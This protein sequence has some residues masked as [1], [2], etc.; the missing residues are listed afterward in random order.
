MK[1]IA[2]VA[3]LL[4]TIVGVDSAT[5]QEIDRSAVD[6]VFADYDQT[7]SPGCALGVV[8]G[9]ALVYGRGYGM[10][11][12]DYGIAITA[13]S[14]FRTA[15]VSKQ[16][17][18][19]AVAI[20]AREGTFSLDDPVRTWIP[21]LPNYPT[22]PTIRHLVHHTSGM[23]DY[24][25]LMYL[26]GLRDD[27]W[28]TDAEVRAA[29]VRQRELNFTPGSDF[30]YS[31]AGYF[32]LGEIIREATGR[33]L[34]DYAHEKIFV[35]LGMTYSHFHDD[36]NRVVPMRA[37]GYAP[38]GDGF[39]VSTTTLDM[40]G[41]GGVFTSIEDLVRWIH[42]LNQDALLPGLNVTLESTRPLSGGEPNDYAF[43]QFVLQHRGLQAFGHGGSFV[44][45]RSMILRFPDQD[46]GI[47]VL[48]NRAD[49]A[50]EDMALR[51]ADIVLAEELGPVAAT[52]DGQGP[53]GADD[54]PEPGPVMDPGQ[55]VGTYYSPELDVHYRLVVEDGELRLLVGPN[56]VFGVRQVATDRLTA[57]RIDLRILREGGEVAGFLVDVGRVKNLSFERAA[58]A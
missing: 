31:N 10:A 42:A 45:Y 28:Y 21:E 5:A 18:A 49:A 27:D 53:A 20:A 46:L 14:V 9:D 56:M 8:R 24:L 1:G 38:S 13:R 54:A 17:T 25:E 55:Y 7:G 23:R 40:V 52:E 3:A 34:A 2:G 15:S 44:G 51:V 19:A 58:G 57:G 36:H 30:L 50:P 48:C 37:T 4:V 26:E 32:I 39:R 16:F 11:S 29:I 6:A 35:P 33:T 47:A 12:L 43:G 41:D 22:D